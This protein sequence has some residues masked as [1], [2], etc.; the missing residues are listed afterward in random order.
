M[1]EPGDVTYERGRIAYKGYCAVT[2]GRSAI[3]GEP[4]PAFEALPE[5]VQ[6][7]WMGAAMDV[8]SQV[9]RQVTERLLAPG[10]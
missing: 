9:I 4:L 10:I 6:L 1:I 8:A 3:T 7:A 2:G 5:A